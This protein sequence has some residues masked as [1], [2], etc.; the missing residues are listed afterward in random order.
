MMHFYLGNDFDGDYH[1][2]PN[3][4]LDII[5]MVSK[6]KNDVDCSMLHNMLGKA[7]WDNFNPCWISLS[8]F[9]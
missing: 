7:I 2:L 4:M 8:R 5:T 6:T 9:V 1:R 3:K